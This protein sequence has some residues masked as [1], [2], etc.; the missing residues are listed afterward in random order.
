MVSKKDDKVFEAAVVS[1]QQ[2]ELLLTIANINPWS[3]Y[4]N[5]PFELAKEFDEQERL[6]REQ[7]GRS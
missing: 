6:Y 1:K 5:N 7:M 2:L 4:L 3:Y